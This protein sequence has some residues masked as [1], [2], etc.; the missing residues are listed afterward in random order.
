MAIET[1]RRFTRGSINGTPSTLYKTELTYTA[2]ADGDAGETTIDNY[3]GRLKGVSL[4][5][6]GKVQVV[7]SDNVDV[8]Q[9]HTDKFVGRIT[10]TSPDPI[11][12]GITVRVNEVAPNSTGKVVLYAYAE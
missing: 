3:F 2:D 6:E 10:F 4:T 12:G 8:L 1:T 5:Q 9:G 7:D 11:V